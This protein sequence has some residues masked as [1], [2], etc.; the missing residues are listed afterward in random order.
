[1]VN[2][3]TEQ[4]RVVLGDTQFIHVYTPNYTDEIVC[5][6]TNCYWVV[7]DNSTII[8]SKH[9][10]NEISSSRLVELPTGGYNILL[11]TFSQHIYIYNKS[12]L[13]WAAKCHFTPITIE[14]IQVEDKPGFLVLLSETGTLEVCY[15]G[16]DVPV[17]DVAPAGPEKDLR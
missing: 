15:L 3:S 9:I 6:G 2:A 17:R 1:M 12:K 5:I 8:E 16:T 7:D 11:G 14:A 10:E 13:I 4:W